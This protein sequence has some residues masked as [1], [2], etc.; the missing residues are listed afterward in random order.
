[1]I[2][3]VGIKIIVLVLIILFFALRFKF[4]LKYE[5]TKRSIG[6]SILGVIWTIIYLFGIFDFA[7]INLDFFV[8]IFVGIPIIL[9][10]F[11]F[12][13]LSHNSLKKNWSPITEE[14]FVRPKKII[15]S[16]IYKRIR[17]PIYSSIFLMVIGFGILISNWL[18]WV[19]PFFSFLILC[20]IK[21]PKE[22]EFLKKEFGDKY[23]EYLNETGRY[24]PKIKFS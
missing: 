1:M 6:R 22:E 23:K 16:G 7:R 8:R 5:L 2:L 11:I 14:K 21:V 15:K 12:I 4:T 19:I 18:L 20:L 17:H 9:L 13:F 10:S 24:F 3:E